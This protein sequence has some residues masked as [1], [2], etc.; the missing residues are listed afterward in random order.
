MIRA[1]WAEMGGEWQGRIRE[2]AVGPNARLLYTHES[3]PLGEVVR[4]INKFSNNVMA[5]QLYLTLAG[6]L[7][8]APA[9]AEGAARAI[10][11]WLVF[12][13]IDA[14][15]LRLE[16]GSGLSRNE[17]ASA[18][19]LMALLQAAWKSPVM[20]ELMAS[21]PVVAADGTMR[22]RLHGEGISGNAHIKTG[23]LSDTRSIA[24]YVLD[25]SG[26]RH[27]VVMIANHPNAPQAEAAFDALLQWTR[28]GARG[29][30]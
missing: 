22:K 20:P 26:R 17:R 3:A 11:Q 6:E 8:G 16:N 14:D 25:R 24:G 21:L 1:L 30:R 15:G 29:K 7:G 12:K 27:A 28:A 18:A 19:M 10:A 23:L 9:Q 5:R 4:D 13:G 2:G